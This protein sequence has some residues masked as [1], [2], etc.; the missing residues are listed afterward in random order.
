MFNLLCSAI[1]SL[2]LPFQVFLMS[3]AAFIWLCQ[4]ATVMELFFIAVG[5]GQ[6]SRSWGHIRRV[7]GLGRN[8]DP[9]SS[10]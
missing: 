1:Q 9:S 8:V 10:G 4:L 6:E 7:M 5:L 2:G 3:C